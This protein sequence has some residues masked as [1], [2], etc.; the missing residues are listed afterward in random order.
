MSTGALF[1]ALKQHPG[2]RAA[3]LALIGVC[4]QTN[5]KADGSALIALEDIAIFAESTI[6]TTRTVLG[7]L[8]EQGLLSYRHTV[9]TD[10]HN[11]TGW[12][13]F[14]PHY[15]GAPL[16]DGLLGE[17]DWDEPEHITSAVMRNFIQRVSSAPDKRHNIGNR[18]IQTNDAPGDSADQDGTSPSGDD[19][20]DTN[21]GTR[22][23]LPGT[24]TEV[25]T[26]KQ[27]P[28]TYP[29][30]TSGPS[31]PPSP[32]SPSS[33]PSAHETADHSDEEDG[34]KRVQKQRKTDP[35]PESLA[36]VDKLPNEA[37]ELSTIEADEL[38]RRVDQVVATRDDL[39]HPAV[40]R[41][42][43]KGR[44][45]PTKDAYRA[46]RKYLQP[47]NLP[48][49]RFDQTDI[50]ERLATAFADVST[51]PA[52]NCLSSIPLPPKCVGPDACNETRHRENAD[53]EPYKC[54][55]CN[56]QALPSPSAR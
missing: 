19:H 23:Q 38:A 22:K 51:E 15:P 30:T 44:L 16:V 3:K 21:A 42:L 45:S 50:S 12:M 13:R 4:D 36:L 14:Y 53:G 27:L 48:R 49:V 46:Y 32:P 24:S 55:D 54:P 43:T 47:A 9:V 40:L 39:D 33:L 18:P 37:R 41:H 34:R 8:R 56:P 10:D 52:P 20:E 6:R 17:I 7:A 26:R 2:N 5:E 1:W 31:S 28:G 11:R 29:E 35:S 25:R